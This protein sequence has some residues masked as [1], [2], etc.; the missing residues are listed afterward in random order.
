MLSI[1]RAILTPPLRPTVTKSTPPTGF[2]S[3]QTNSKGQTPFPIRASSPGALV[4]SSN[5]PT[6]AGHLAD[7][8]KIHLQ[9]SISDINQVIERS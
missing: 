3:R 5:N 9:L 8:G 4:L 7:R 1:G 6:Q 2:R